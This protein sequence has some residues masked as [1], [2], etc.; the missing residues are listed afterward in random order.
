MKCARKCVIIAKHMDLLTCLSIITLPFMTFICLYSTSVRA[1][2]RTQCWASILACRAAVA[3][4]CCTPW[5]PHPCC[6]PWAP[7]NEVSCSHLFQSMACVLNDSMGSPGVFA[8]SHTTHFPLP[9]SLYPQV[10]LRS[11]KFQPEVHPTV[12]LI[13]GAPGIKTLPVDPALGKCAV[14][15]FVWS[16]RWDSRKIYPCFQQ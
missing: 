1:F 10:F 4:P 12:P 15:Q 6:T 14:Q 2:G 16:F 3:R 9:S 13:P 7:R 11:F 8:D 5:A